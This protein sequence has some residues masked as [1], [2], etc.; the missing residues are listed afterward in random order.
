MQRLFFLFQGEYKR[1][2]E[3]GSNVIFSRF[4][5]ERRTESKSMTYPMRGVELLCPCGAVLC[6]TQP[7][8]LSL[9]PSP[10]FVYFL[11]ASRTP[12]TLL[13]GINT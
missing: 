6:A 13:L 5:R 2:G 11:L 9:F 1:N 10:P 7:P 12:N 3:N 4:L 8:A